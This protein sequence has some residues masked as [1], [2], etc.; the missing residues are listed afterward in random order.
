MLEMAWW[1]G[2]THLQ[3]SEASRRDMLVVGCCTWSHWIG[4]DVDF[5]GF[6]Q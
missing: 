1:T 3:E 5:G 2:W 6:S 4:L